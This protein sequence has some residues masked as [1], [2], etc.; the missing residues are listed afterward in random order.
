[1]SWIEGVVSALK[2]DSQIAAIVGA[3]VMPA[4]LAQGDIFP[5][6]LYNQVYENP[7]YCQNG[8]TMTM[9]TTQFTILSQKYAEVET[10]AAHIKR[11]LFPY[12]S[13][14]VLGVEYLNMGA[15]DYFDGAKVFQR[16]Y[17]YRFFIK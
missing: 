16:S 10:L 6:I 4:V 15:D 17:D 12:K 13:S 9:N 8:V 2:S 5:C 14:L 11:V 3:K 1:M 7:D